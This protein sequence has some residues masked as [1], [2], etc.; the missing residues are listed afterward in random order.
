MKVSVVLGEVGVYFAMEDGE[1]GCTAGG[2]GGAGEEDSAA[3]KDNNE[4]IAAFPLAKVIE[5]GMHIWRLLV[6]M[7]Q[8]QKT[9]M[10]S[11]GETVPSLTSLEPNQN[12]WT[13]MP[14]ITKCANPEVKPQTPERRLAFSF[15]VPND[16]S[17]RDCSWG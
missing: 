9:A 15:M 11:P 3:A 16:F 14:I 5:C 2:A 4:A 1:V 10:T 12:P 6:A 8:A 7:R 17:A 13:N